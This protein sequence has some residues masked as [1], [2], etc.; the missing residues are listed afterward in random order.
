MNR[1]TDVSLISLLPVDF[2]WEIIT[3]VNKDPGSQLLLIPDHS[4]SPLFWHIIPWKNMKS[5][6]SAAL[7]FLF[8]NHNVLI[9]SPAHSPFLLPSPHSYQLRGTRR[10]L[11]RPSRP[12]I[13]T[14][15]PAALLLSALWNYLLGIMY[16]KMFLWEIVENHMLSE[17]YD[18][19]CKKIACR[20]PILHHK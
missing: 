1:R 13:L 6:C 16:S 15:T 20:L 18:D 14:P 4:H 8:M 3:M 2:G 9:L 11:S 10:G 19:H 7:W 17:A 12:L 5:Q